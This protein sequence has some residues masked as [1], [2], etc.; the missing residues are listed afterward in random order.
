MRPFCLLTVSILLFDTCNMD[1]DGKSETRP[2]PFVLLMSDGKLE[3][4]IF[5]TDDDIEF[6]ASEA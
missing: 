4:F 5:M 3:P 2:C 6:I 1:E